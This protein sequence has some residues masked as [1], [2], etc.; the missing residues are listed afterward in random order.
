[1]NDEIKNTMANC[2]GIRK[3]ARGVSVFPTYY[4]SVY[5]REKPPYKI[6]SRFQAPCILAVET[7]CDETAIAIYRKKLLAHKLF[8][9]A[10]IH[11]LYKGVVPEI[12]AR[13]HLQRLNPLV[14][15][16]LTAAKI[17]RNEVSCVAYTMGPGLITALMT[18]A[19]F[20]RSFAYGLGVPALSIH[21]LEGH[22]LSPLLTKNK[23]AFPYIAL[24]VSGGHSQLYQVNGYGDYRL[25]GESLDDAAGEAFD[26]IANLL[27]LPYPGGS[28]LESLA[29]QG[30]E[31][32]Y[33]LTVPMARTKDYNFSFSG[34]KTQVR[35]L[36]EKL[37]SKETYADLAASCQKTLVQSLLGKT[38]ALAYLLN[39]NRI[40][41][42]GGVSANLYLRQEA[43]KRAAS[44][45]IK[46]FY[47][48]LE[49]CTDNAAMI[50]YAAAMRFSWGRKDG[51]SIRA[52]AR[53]PIPPKY[54]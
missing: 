9:Q 49:Y 16:C 26:K 50:A 20:A 27:D 29:S 15:D 22:L 51:L 45:Q 18:G 38:F 6:L 47:P 39:A 2:N 36:M 7:S 40:A 28:H 8:S 17:N 48:P 21:H 13:N 33:A 14:N 43:E 19:A 31:N 54:A 23:P 37:K 32:T 44:D 1:M 35:Y 46:L 52:Q 3:R 34:L 53:C 25:Y 5:N 4:C 24:L 10:N 30:D 11:K 42:V 41:I 12:A